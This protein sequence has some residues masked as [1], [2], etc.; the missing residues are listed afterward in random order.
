MCPHTPNVLS[1][2][3]IR[4]YPLHDFQR[5]RAHYSHAARQALAWFARLQ[6]S[7]ANGRAEPTPGVRPSPKMPVYARM[8]L[9]NS[10]PLSEALARFP[11]AVPPAAARNRLRSPGRWAAAASVLLLAGWILAASGLID[12]WRADY[13]TVAGEQRRIAL[14]DGS[15]VILNTDSALALDFNDDRRGVRLLA[16]EAYFES[17]LRHDLSSSVPTTRPYGW[18]V[19]RGSVRETSVAV[20]GGIVACG[21]D[22]NTSVQVTAGRY[23]S[24]KKPSR[25]RK[26][27]TPETRSPGSE[28][29]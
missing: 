10:P 1:V 16:G 8:K 7:E 2:V 11:A 15:I 22:Q 19:I 23:R 3:S 14:A 24:Q 13:T 20:D 27:S 25:R 6:D 17:A 9:W 28:D 12:R 5:R 4:P 26:P 29:A 21:N 18:W